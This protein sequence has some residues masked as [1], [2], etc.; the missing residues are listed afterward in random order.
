MDPKHSWPSRT[1]KQHIAWSQSTQLTAHYWHSLEGINPNRQSIALW[2]CSAPIIF[3]A[4]ADALA[5]AMHCEG[6][7]YT[8]HYLDDFFFC[9]PANSTSCA[10]DVNIAIPLCNRLGLPVAPE[11][12]EGPVIAFTFLGIEI[13]SATMTLSLPQDKLIALKAHLAS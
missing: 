7:Q 11:K 1:S 3:S 12:V 8:I 10:K 13:N 4:A 2:P 9:G 6:V 5:W